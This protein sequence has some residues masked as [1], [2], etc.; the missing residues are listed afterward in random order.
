MYLWIEY[1]HNSIDDRLEYAKEADI[2]HPL[3][4]WEVDCPVDTLLITHISKT[5]SSWE[6]ISE[7]VE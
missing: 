1:L 2:I 5:A 6:E 3:I 4:H 7:L